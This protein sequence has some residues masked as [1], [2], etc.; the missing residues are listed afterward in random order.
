MTGLHIAIDMDDVIVDFT[1]TILA[2]VERDLG[3]V[4]NFEDV[5]SFDMNEGALA[6]VPFPGGVTWM[7]WLA[8]RPSIW[9][10]A[11]PVIGALAGLDTLRSAGHTLEI[12][13][14]KPAWAE[15]VVWGFLH[16]HQ[17]PVQ[18]ATIVPAGARKERCSDAD[19]LI[20]DS[21]ENVLTWIDTCRPAILFD[22]P[23]N[24]DVP[25]STSIIRAW[26]WADVLKI[27]GSGW[28]A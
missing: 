25:P 24:R 16:D 8:T 28:A 23:W 7:E 14:K 5:T 15:Y 3:A 19:I 1:P 18:R 21:P 10:Y 11:P 17:L 22:R 6:D 27:V 4:V 13:T 12:L 20:D 9:R 2:A 26:G